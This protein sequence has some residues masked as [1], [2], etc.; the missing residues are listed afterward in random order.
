ME[1]N[2]LI[3]GI[4]AFEVAPLE[5][6]EYALSLVKR[7][8]VSRRKK[9]EAETS[10][11]GVNEASIEARAVTVLHENGSPLTSEEIAEKINTRFG[12][13]NPKASV[14][15][16][17]SRSMQKKPDSPFMRVRHGLFGLREWEDDEAGT[18]APAS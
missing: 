13:E 12:S 11:N 14:A 16:A 17:L 2:A 6:A 7:V 9:S 15:S 18:E 10:D 3:R 5:D 8:M 1:L 4:K